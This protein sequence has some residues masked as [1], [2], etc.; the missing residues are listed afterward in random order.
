MQCIVKGAC[1]LFRHLPVALFAADIT[2]ADHFRR[3]VLTVAHQRIALYTAGIA[4]HIQGRIQIGVRLHRQLISAAHLMTVGHG[5]LQVQIYILLQTVGRTILRDNGFMCGNGH[6]NGFL[7]GAVQSFRV[8]PAGDIDTYAFHLFG[9]GHIALEAKHIKAHGNT[10]QGGH[11][12]GCH[13]SLPALSEH[14]QRPA[15]QHFRREVADHGHHQQIDHQRH[16]GAF[17]VADQPVKPQAQRQAAHKGDHIAENGL[18]PGKGH[19]V[20]R[21]LTA[22]CPVQQ[23]A[24]AQQY[25]RRS[26]V[27]AHGRHKLLR[28]ILLDGN[29]VEVRSAVGCFT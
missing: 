17:A 14:T 24:H 11:G 21:R 18:C 4:Q 2:A 6:H 27:G 16:P 28:R 3:P 7:I 22:A 15:D 8:I 19:A 9:L 12:A 10:Q 13:Q 26:R 25:Q 5:I 29:F 23:I 1:L 20:C